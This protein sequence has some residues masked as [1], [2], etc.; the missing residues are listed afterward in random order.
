MKNFLR[1]KLIL[2][3]VV[4]ALL[5]LGGGIALAYTQLWSGIA[6]ITIDS[7]V[8]S[9]GGGGGNP[10]AAPLPLKVSS[11]NATK[12]T[13]VDG[14]WVVS[15]SPGGT[16]TLIVTIE[17]PR[18]VLA[19]IECLTDNTTGG[20]IKLADD[21]V[22]LRGPGEDLIIPAGESYECKWE[23]SCTI[24]AEPGALPDVRLS[25]RELE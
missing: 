2:I 21:Q 18:D 1:A 11:V 14:N 5:L 25:I 22:W 4:L 10:P 6:S 9:G 15:L 20:T 8:K 23:L 12:G 13:V 19:R 7:S 16:A 24:L 17:N 3:G